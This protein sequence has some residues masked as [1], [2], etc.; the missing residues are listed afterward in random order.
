M[1][2]LNSSPRPLVA[3]LQAAGSQTMSAVLL[4]LV[5]GILNLCLGYALA[6]HLGYAPP[7]LVEAW[8]ALTSP[9]LPAPGLSPDGTFRGPGA[10]LPEELGGDFYGP[11]EQHGQHQ[12][13]EQHEPPEETWLLKLHAAMIRSEARGRELE[14]RLRGVAGQGDVETIQQCA[15]ELQEDCQI[16]LA[17]EREAAERF[18]ERIGESDRLRHLGEELE[19]ANLEQAAQIEMTLNDLRQT[20]VESDPEAANR[21]L[22]EE[23]GKLGAARRKLQGLVESLG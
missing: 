3:A 5:I 17:E 7:S 21:W 12:R 22:L 9:R 16:C 6:V 8:D 2:G 19:M 1:A 23:I 15:A 18:R 4:T 14:A 11:N 10:T 20:D 13:H